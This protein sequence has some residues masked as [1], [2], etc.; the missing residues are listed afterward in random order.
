G[1][2]LLEEGR[3]SRLFLF[4]QGAD[5]LALLL[6]ERYE[7]YQKNGCLHM[8][9]SQRDLADVT[10]LCV[11]SIGRGIKKFME[12]GL[13]TKEGKQIVINRQQYEELKRMV[14]EKVDL[15]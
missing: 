12:D 5:R 4:M 2:Y 13:L 3:N 9:G 11:K 14:S 8:K 1:E 15:E 6:V 10:G 7:K